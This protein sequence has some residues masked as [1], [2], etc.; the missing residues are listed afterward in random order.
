MI[1]KYALINVM[2]K[3]LGSSGAR[4]SVRETAKKTGLSVF[5]AKQA[6]DY[7][8]EKG[9]ISFE[10]TGPTYQYK[11]DLESFLTRQWK[12]LFTL[13]EI[14]E[15][16]IIPNILRQSKNISSVVLYG[17]CGS[18]RD[19]ALSDIDILV[20]A[21]VGSDKKKE[22]LSQARGTH[23][24]INVQVYTPMEWRKKASVDKAFYDTVVIESVPLYGVKPVVL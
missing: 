9:M 17:S 3:I 12:I 22:I 4:Y 19:D 2:R 10:K 5:A 18:G 13:E 16:G 11:A 21:D 1:K 24:E 6:L 23:R 8:H 20:V 14:N 15:A 7:M